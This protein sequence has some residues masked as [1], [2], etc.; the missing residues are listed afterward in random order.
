MSAL[1]YSVM[2]LTL[3]QQQHE[4]KLVGLHLHRT[5]RRGKS[6][7]LTQAEAIYKKSFA[8]FH[9]LDCSKRNRHRIGLMQL[10]S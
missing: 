2:H 10:R 5:C 1:Q 6:G 9:E 8:L 7:D 4:K 3:E